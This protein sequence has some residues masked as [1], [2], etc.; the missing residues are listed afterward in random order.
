MSIEIDE[1]DMI[2]PEELLGRK[3][4]QNATTGFNIGT[5][6]TED[7]LAI[8]RLIVGTELENSRVSKIVVVKVGDDIVS[9]II[10]IFDSMS[11]LIGNRVY[12]QSCSE[13]V[14]EVYSL[15]LLYE[16]AIIK[17]SNITQSGN[18]RLN[19]TSSSVVMVDEIISRLNLHTSE[20]QRIYWYFMGDDG[21]MNNVSGIVKTPHPCTSLH[22]PWLG[23]DVDKFLDEYEAS[24]SPVLILIGPPGTGKT[25]LINY[26][27][28]KYKKLSSVTYDQNVLTKDQFYIQFITHYENNL[29]ILEDADDIIQRTAEGRNR[30]L[31]KILNVGDGVVDTSDKK[32]II[33]ANIDSVENVDP[34]ISRKGRCFAALT[35]RLH[36]ADEANALAEYLNID[37]K[38][39]GKTSLA[40]FF[41]GRNPQTE[42][43]RKF[44]FGF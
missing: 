33:T 5:G 12:T 31:S 7:Q 26:Y 11:D 44:G 38:F 42:S 20:N 27:I 17:L 37:R 34:A 16:R 2:Y 24:E 32:I 25:S 28:H 36:T 35:S 1:Y 41:N 14:K 15:H 13:G 10:S 9:S 39:T 8:A 40:E 43:E 21:S 6:L 30:V 23:S 4:A 19:I 22:V 18:P 3:L 29:L